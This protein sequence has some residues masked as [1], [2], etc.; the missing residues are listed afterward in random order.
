MV[1]GFEPQQ[2]AG[3]ICSWSDAF[4]QFCL[5]DGQEGKHYTSI[6]KGSLVFSPDSQR[7][8][9]VACVAAATEGDSGQWSVVVDGREM[10]HYGRDIHTLIFSPDSQRV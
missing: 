5:V 2:P 1:S 6:L 3:G 9:Y 4:Q 10:G 8:A 7:V